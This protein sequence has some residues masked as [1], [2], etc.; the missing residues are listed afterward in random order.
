MLESNTE[1]ML[2]TERPTARSPLSTTAGRGATAPGGAKTPAHSKPARRTTAPRGT[3]RL[4]TMAVTGGVSVLLVEDDPDLQW[5]LARSLTIEGH[6]VVGTSSGDGA[7][8]VISQWPVDLVLVSSRLPGMG[9]LE[10]IRQIRDRYSDVP[11]VLM[12]SPGDGDLRTGARLAGVTA[13]L[14]KPFETEAL[15]RL[16][17]ALQVGPALL[18]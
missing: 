9:G 11:V 4:G 1:K 15:L 10:V 16:L 17:L 8:A 12:T 3:K 5:A 13:C 2:E 14:Q 6:R 18:S 7:I